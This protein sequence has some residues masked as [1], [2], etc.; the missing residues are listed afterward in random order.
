MIRTFRDNEELYKSEGKWPNLLKVIGQSKISVIILSPRYAESKWCLKELAEIIEHHNREKGHI[1]LPIFYMVHPQD[2]RRQT[3]PYEEAFKQHET[4]DIDEETIRS[5]KNAL[6]EVGRLKGWHI[7]SRKKEVDVADAVYEVVRSHLSKKNNKLETD[8]LVGI[9]DQV[10]EVVDMLDLDSQGVKILRMVSVGSIVEAKKII[11]E[12]VAQFKIL[13]VLEDV[14]EK[15]NFEEVLVNSKSFASGS[16]FIVTSRDIKVLRR[17]SGGQS[18]LYKVQGM[19][20][21]HS[22]QLFC[23]HAFKKYSPQSGFEALSNAII[24]TTGGLPLTL[25]VIG[26]L[27]YQEEEVV[28]KE[29]LEQLRKISEEEVIEKLKICYDGLRYEEQQIFLDVACFYIGENKEFPSY[30]WTSCNFHPILYV[31]ILVQR[32]MLEIGDDMCF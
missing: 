8:E 28:W 10:D 12:R 31:N 4:N 5:W 22:L 14:D 25:K 21:I 18:K 17:L 20:L 3:G 26:S 19:N 11:R 27:L 29:K 9:D 24:S 16:R 2:V 30:M 13:V 15:F 32:S 23:K 6:N 1:I 7:T